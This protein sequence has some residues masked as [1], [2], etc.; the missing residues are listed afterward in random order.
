MVSGPDD[1]NSVRRTGDEV[2]EGGEMCQTSVRCYYIL[3]H[4]IVIETVSA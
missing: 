4:I 1:F 3:M 2:F